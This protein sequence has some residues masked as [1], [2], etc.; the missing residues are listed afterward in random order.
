MLGPMLFNIF[1]SNLLLVM[2]ETEF[3]SYGDDTTLHDAGNTI[4]D[5][6]SFLQESC[7][8]TLEKVI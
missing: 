2:K 4:E 1:L 7:K 8:K 6:N 3:T 5:A